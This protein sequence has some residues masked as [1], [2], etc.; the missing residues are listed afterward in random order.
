[1]NCRLCG[2]PLPPPKG[3]RPR[4][5]CSDECRQF[6]SLRAQMSRRLLEVIPHMT[7]EARLEV[8]SSLWNVANYVN[9]KA[10]T[11]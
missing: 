7:P 1:M 6:D 11:K 9:G 2:S 10:G 4:D 5:F 8:R 3:G